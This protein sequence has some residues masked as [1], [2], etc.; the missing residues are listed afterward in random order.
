MQVRVI[1]EKCNTAGMCVKLCPE[2]FRFQEGSKKAQVIMDKIP[3]H[4]VDKCIKAVDSCPNQA[5]VARFE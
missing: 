5:I 3:S 2:V 4:L 1:Q